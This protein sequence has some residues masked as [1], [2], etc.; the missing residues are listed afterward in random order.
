MQASILERANKCEGAT[1]LKS[2]YRVS[3]SSAVKFLFECIRAYANCVRVSAATC[4]HLFQTR[5]T[6]RHTH[7]KLRDHLLANGLQT[8]SYHFSF[9]IVVLAIVFV[10]NICCV[11]LLLQFFFV[12]QQQAYRVFVRCWGWHSPSA[13]LPC[14]MTAVLTRSSCSSALFVA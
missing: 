3:L 2:I 5:A 6:H 7:T 14:H 8:K 1:K 4:T 10:A 12:L 11:L 13:T 9:S